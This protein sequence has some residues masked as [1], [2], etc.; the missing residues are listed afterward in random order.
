M[1]R[2]KETLY[3]TFIISLDLVTSNGN[4]RHGRCY[5]FPFLEKNKDNF[6]F[7]NLS[8]FKPYEQRANLDGFRK[9]SFVKIDARLSQ[10]NI[11]PDHYYQKVSTFQSV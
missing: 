6:F 8:V 2:K 9:I 1:L 10:R 3:L 5:F 7:N 11:I 4:F